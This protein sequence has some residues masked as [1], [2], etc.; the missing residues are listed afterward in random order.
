MRF[1]SESK[2]LPH[3]RIETLEACLV[4]AALKGKA[5]QSGLGGSPQLPY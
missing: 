3:Y 5:E 2:E 4:H 1:R